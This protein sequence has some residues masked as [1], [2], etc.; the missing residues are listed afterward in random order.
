[1][2]GWRRCPRCGSGAVR[3]E[4]SGCGI[5]CFTYLLGALYIFTALMIITAILSGNIINSTFST[6]FSIL[7]LVGIIMLTKNLREN[8]V[9]KPKLIYIVNHVNFISKINVK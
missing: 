9:M 3:I 6:L 2:S 5:G 8:L 7:I 4:N 1:M